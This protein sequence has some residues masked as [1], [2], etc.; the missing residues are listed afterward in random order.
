MAVSGF[1]SKVYEMGELDHDIL[2]FFEKAGFTEPRSD[3]YN[4][5]TGI[6]TIG[7][8]IAH[9][10][11]GDAILIGVSISGNNYKNEWLSNL[12]IENETRPKGF[13][14]A[15]KKVMRRVEAY[16]K[17]HQ[18]SGNLRIWVAGYSR[19]AAVS[20]LFAADA[21]ES[22]QFDAVYAYTFATPRTTR[23]A[24]PKRYRCIFNMINPEDVVPLIPFP[25][26]GY[27]RYGRDLF[28]PSIS[29]DSHYNELYLKATDNADFGINDLPVFNPRMRN[30]LHTVLDYFAYFVNSADTYSRS[31]QGLL[32]NYWRDRDIKAL[33][34]TIIQN[35]DFEGIL[36][37]VRER[38]LRFSQRMYEIFNFIDFN[39]NMF[40]R[41]FM[42]NQFGSDD[43]EY[44]DNDFSLQE[45]FAFGHY[46]KSYRFWLFASDDPDELFT[47]DPRY[48][49]LSIVGNVDIEVLD[50]NGDFIQQFDHE[51]WF[52]TETDEKYNP[53]FHGG[54]SNTILYMERYGNRTMA[55]L[56]C[57]QEKYTFYILSNEAQ[58]VQ[59][60][61]M[62]YS[63]QKLK[64]DVLYMY[65]DY[66]D[67]GEGYPELIEPSKEHLVTDEQLIEENVLPVSSPWDEYIDYSPTAVMRMEYAG[68]FL[69]KSV[70]VIIFLQVILFQ[71]LGLMILF[72]VF[73][74]R[75]LIVFTRK[76]AFG[77][78]PKP[79]KDQLE[80]VKKVAQ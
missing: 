32:L 65:D 1:R 34:N 3:D 40:F 66:Y 64:A 68:A 11:V 74:I 27:E 75:R 8:L 31:L 78:E 14:H 9:K 17:E 44:W 5:P 35:V 39:A 53:D 67:K 4:K 25:E 79:N 41:S 6:N 80:K 19:A 18:L 28:L 49:H 72:L 50:E 55:E 20:N 48:L 51:G 69:P 70:P 60:S 2:D 10:K 77:I 61:V 63:A 59:V 58:Y 12:T 13:N 47:E 57:D 21:I 30:Q 43:A 15:A 37:S 71:F 76:K 29:T 52:I 38:N 16:I 22:K 46:D 23:E 56:P 73:S 42:A 54:V 7:T 24:N 36:Q 62:E 33:V 26:W 45:N